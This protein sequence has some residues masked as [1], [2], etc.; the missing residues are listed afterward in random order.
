MYTGV[1][2]EE[3]K[4]QVYLFF[5]SKIYKRFQNT[6]YSKPIRVQKFW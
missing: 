1:K 3:T 2:G 6:L 5:F 4:V